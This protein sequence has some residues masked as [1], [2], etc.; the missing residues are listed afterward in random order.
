MDWFPEMSIG[1]SCWH[2]FL[3]FSFTNNVPHFVVDT[4]HLA[5]RQDCW[6][7]RRMGVMLTGRYS[8][9]NRSLQ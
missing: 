6:R 8:N 4:G 3:A 2:Q 1:K 9:V 7:F 5:S